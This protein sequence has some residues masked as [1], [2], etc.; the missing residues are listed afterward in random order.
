MTAADWQVV[1]TADGAV[2]AVTG[3][4]PPQWVG[5]RLEDRADLPPDVRQAVRALLDELHGSTA[6]I[7]TRSVRAASPAAIQLIA[8]EAVP[9]RR[10]AVDLRALL[11]SIVK[12]MRPQASPDRPVARALGLKMVFDVVSAHGGRVDVESRTDSVNHG[13]IVRLMFPVL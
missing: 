4:A 8:V 12:L 11:E 7:A 1:L 2:L 3:G 10:A 13:T 9:L 6:P 5:T